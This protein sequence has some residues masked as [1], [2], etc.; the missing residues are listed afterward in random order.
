MD[1]HFD[2]LWLAGYIHMYVKGRIYIYIYV[3]IYKFYIWVYDFCISQPQVT[4]PY[5][6]INI[7]IY[8]ILC[9]LS[10]PQKIWRSLHL[11][12]LT[13]ST[14][15]PKPE[16]VLV[17]GICQHRNAE[18]K[19]QTRENNGIPSFNIC[20]RPSCLKKDPKILLFISC[21]FVICTYRIGRWISIHEMRWLSFGG[22]E[23]RIKIE[24]I[25]SWNRILE[26]CVKKHLL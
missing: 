5:G 23:S 9:C 26:I 4:Q 6:D 13:S 22:H 11:N 14:K 3:Y 10:E 7:Y 16:V 17:P 1:Y 20:P 12:I 21:S 24:V 25:S 19:K 18:Q 2:S 8:M 15:R